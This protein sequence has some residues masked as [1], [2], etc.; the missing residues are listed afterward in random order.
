MSVRTDSKGDKLMT[1]LEHHTDLHLQKF[2]EVIFRVAIQVVM[3][4]AK[5]HRPQYVDNT[6]AALMAL[7]DRLNASGMIIIA[8]QVG[9]IYM[10]HLGGTRLKDMRA[11][12]FGDYHNPYSKYG[13]R[14]GRIGAKRRPAAATKNAPVQT[15]MNLE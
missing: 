7:Q 3:L 5:R 9:V 12:I 10:L 14:A 6:G 13:G 4:D 8:S 2:S 15:S 1:R 11:S